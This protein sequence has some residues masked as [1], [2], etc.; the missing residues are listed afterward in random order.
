LKEIE[1]K[2]HVLTMPDVLRKVT[3]FQTKKQRDVYYDTHEYKLLRVG[4]FMRIRDNTS[5]E[6]KLNS[7]DLSHLY[8]EELDYVLS[9]LHSHSDAIEK[10]LDII[11]LVVPV[12]LNSFEDILE[13]NQLIELADIDKERAAYNYINGIKVYY[14]KVNNLGNFIEAD[15]MIPSDSSLSV[16]KEAE[17]S[18]LEVLLKNEIIVDTNDR[19]RLGYVEL[20]LK[21]HNPV[22]FELGLYK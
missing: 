2:F 12:K 18:L 11:S 3:P 17:N 19:V 13:S 15:L 7:G 20:Y 9:E 16:I 8:C 6:F 1:V 10:L 5:L 14:D 21:K 4:N 22:A